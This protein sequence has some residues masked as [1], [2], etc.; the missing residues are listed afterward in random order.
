MGPAAD[1]IDAFADWLHRIGY[2][3][4]SI[5]GLLRSLAG[6]TDWMIANKFT[7]ENLLAGFEACR[8]ALQKK[9]RVLHSRGPNQAFVDSR[10]VVHPLP[11]KPRGARSADSSTIRLRA[12]ADFGG[13]PLVDA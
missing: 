4:V 12:L 7:A 5:I 9:P 13:V 1:H 6:W 11:A 2:K 3:P 10:R 8:L